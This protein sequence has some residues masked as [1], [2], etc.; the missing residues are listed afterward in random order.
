MSATCFP[1]AG[2]Q[3]GFTLIEVIVTIIISAVLAVILGQV[4]A[5]Q[6]ARSYRPIQVIN[7]NLALRAV[8]ENIAA[9]CRRQGISVQVLQARVANGEYWNNPLFTF[10]GN[11]PIDLVY[12][13][14]IGFNATGNEATE[15]SSC[16]TS[17][18]LKVTIAAQGTSHRLTSLFAP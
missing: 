9:D 4:I 14:C 15:D 8:M 11:I 16:T 12:N 6:A 7:E 3:R 13:S 10:T 5:N 2:D 1:I 17:N 18:I